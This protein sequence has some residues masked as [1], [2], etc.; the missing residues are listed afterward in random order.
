MKAIILTNSRDVKI[1]NVNEKGLKFRWKKRT[2][3]IDPLSIG[4][5][6]YNQD[7]VLPV[8]VSYYFESNPNPI[9]FN[10]DPNSK[11]LVDS[12]E[13]TRERHIAINA[14]EQLN[15][16]GGLAGVLEAVTGLAQYITIYNVFAAIVAF[17]LIYSYL[18]GIGF[19]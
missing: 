3:T 18:Q 11:T 19:L 9:P 14:I 6:E 17:S 13:S 10:I 16:R 8:V 15:K 12:S 1:L 4:L 5:T 7:K 2:Y